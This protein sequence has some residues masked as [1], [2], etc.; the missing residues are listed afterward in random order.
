MLNVVLLVA[1]LVPLWLRL[2]RD[3][4]AGLAYAVLV[5][6]SAS[7]FIRI[8]MPE[9]LPQ[10]T[11][12]RLIL[13]IL[14]LFW[15]KE[16]RLGRFKS[17]VPFSRLFLLWGLVN[18][19]S[20]F[21]TDISFGRSLKRYL[22]FVLEFWGFYII[23]TT[24]ITT[25]VDALKILRAAVTGL[26][27]VAVLAFV[28]KYTGF[29]PTDLLV[30]AG[31]EARN[32]RDVTATYQHRIL[33]GTGLAMG[34]PLA[35]VLAAYGSTASRKLLYIG[36]TAMLAGG[37]YFA[38]SRGPW[39]GVAIAAVVLLMLS[40]RKIRNAVIWIMAVTVL[41][42]V[43]RPGV[44]ETIISSV[45][46]TANPDSLKGGT[47]MYRFELWRVAWT[48][49]CKSPIRLLFGY[50]QGAGLEK[51]IEWDLSFRDKTTQIWSWDNHYA[52]DLYQTGILG[53][54]VK[55]ALYIAIVHTVYR[56]LCRASASHR[57]LLAGA[58]AS[59]L[60]FLFMM[61]NVLIFVK[62]L[63]FLFAAVAASAFA[64]RMTEQQRVLAEERPGNGCVTEQKLRLERALRHV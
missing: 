24:V 61:S 28:E 37:C 43:L 5:C 19:F 46:A 6:V 40:T 42:L 63:N 25:R 36:I 9:V 14:F 57:D 29:N 44:F 22:D 50:G 8:P 58:F 7:T 17:P 2:R 35:L 3:F 64:F 16:R 32:L 56:S 53:F 60:V 18:L 4:V 62:Q 38:H 23:A 33:L 52:Y 26:G 1:L 59:M 21:F 49:I 47:F 41:V 30:S 31:D 20:L 55:V 10:L 27:V 34:L 12:F 48:E 45:K 13:I 11:I 15:F 39:L 54:G 51:E